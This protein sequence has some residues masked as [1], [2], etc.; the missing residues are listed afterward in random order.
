MAF[1]DYEK[2]TKQEK[3]A[4]ATRIVAAIHESHGRFL[5]ATDDDNAW[6]EVDANA[7]RNKVAHFFRRRRSIKQT[8]IRPG[9]TVPTKFS[10][11]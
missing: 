4:I 11:I 9:S 6:I 1:D 5:K 3:T 2:A 8:G 7:A 10:A